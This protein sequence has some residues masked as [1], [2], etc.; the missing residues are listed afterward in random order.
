MLPYSLQAI[1]VLSSGISDENPAAWLSV[2]AELHSCNS[3]L[4]K[5]EDSV[6]S[7]YINDA[8]V[9]R[10]KREIDR[11]NLLRHKTVAE[12]DRRLAETLAG[13]F[14]ADSERVLNSESLGQMLDRLSVLILKRDNFS[15]KGDVASLEKV[16]RHIRH[17]AACFDNAV[18]LITKGALPPGCD[19]LKDYGN[20]GTA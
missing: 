12:L 8:D 10:I 15:K 6:R 3:L 11:T 20:G 7:Q 16:M 5:L 19:E 14:R 9:A 17:I 18:E 13:N 4:W 1:N 2:L